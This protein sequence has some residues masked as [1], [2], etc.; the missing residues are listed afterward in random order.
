MDSEARAHKE[1]F[2]SYKNIK[3]TLEAFR[4]L[5]TE[6][7]IPKRTIFDT[8]ATKGDVQGTKFL[9]AVE[10]LKKKKERR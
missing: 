8:E 1:L 6:L 7:G 10:Q 2:D 5:Q 4:K 9:E 3:E